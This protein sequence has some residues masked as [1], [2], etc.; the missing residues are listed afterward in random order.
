MDRWYAQ[1]TLWNDVKAAGR[2]YVC[3]VRDNSAYRVLEERPLDTR[4]PST[5]A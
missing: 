4:R 2:S 1:F 5:P 3:R